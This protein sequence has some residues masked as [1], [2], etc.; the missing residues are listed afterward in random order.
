MKP[1][2]RSGGG[3]ARAKQQILAQCV[4]PG[5]APASIAPTITRDPADDQVLAA[6]L[7]ASRSDRLG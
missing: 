5:A 3:T 2:R 1:I 4:E 7:G 6:A